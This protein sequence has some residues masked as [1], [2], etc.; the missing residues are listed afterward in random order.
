MA[1]INT[2]IRPNGYILLS[3]TYRG[4]RFQVATGL[5]TSEK[6]TGKEFPPTESNHKAKTRRLM[7]LYLECEEYMLQHTGESVEQMKASLRSIVTGKEQEKEEPQKTKTLVDYIYEFAQTKGG[8]TG[9]IYR[10]TA[11]RV[12]GFDPSI[13]FPDANKAWLENYRDHQLKQ[14]HRALNGV[15][16]DLRNIRAVFNWAIDNEIT[17]CYPFR[18]FQ[19]KTERTPHL[20]LP[21]EEIVRLRD[22]EVE[23]YQEVY[24]DIFMLG[25][26]LIGINISDLLELKKENMRYGR[27]TYRR[28]KTHR[29]YDIK[30]EPE[31]AAIIDKYKGKE[32]LLRF[33][34]DG[35]NVR[36]FNRNV[37]DAIKRIGN[38]EIV[39]NKRGAYIKKSITP[40]FPDITWYTA[41]RSWATIA[42]SLDIPKETI[43]KALGHSEWDNTTTDIYIAFDNK[44]IDEANRKVLDR[45]L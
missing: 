26:Y 24:R 9:D 12:C 10:L 19:I 2:Y 22:C 37:N 32:H 36:T 16:I 31:A 5:R 38:L 18:K 34:D 3:V 30:V 41:R 43:G 40:L 20:F 42:A 15:A 14:R 25:F 27:I 45:L 23:P 7:R 8:S 11:K 21:A 13:T 35:C 44:K 33:L 17:T 29:L 1:N 39:K 4:K 6:F 28:N